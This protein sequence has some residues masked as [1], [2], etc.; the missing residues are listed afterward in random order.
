MLI[1][2]LLTYANYV[3]LYVR[4]NYTSRPLARPG[5]T[6]PF[7]RWPLCEVAK[8]EGKARPALMTF[9]IELVVDEG[10]GQMDRVGVW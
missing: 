1:N 9:D 5:A 8:F 4:T 7:K 6:T 3:D 10:A 2:K